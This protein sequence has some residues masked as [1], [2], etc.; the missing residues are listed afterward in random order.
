MEEKGRGLAKTGTV[1]VE[2]LAANIKGEKLGKQTQHLLGTLE[3]GLSHTWDRHLA[4]AS[5]VI[6]S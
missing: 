2:W 1:E 3:D 5:P 6:V 4:Q